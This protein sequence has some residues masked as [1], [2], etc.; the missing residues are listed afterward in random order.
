MLTTA[1]KGTPIASRVKGKPALVKSLRSLLIRVH[2]YGRCRA[3]RA[4]DLQWT[5]EL[6][7]ALYAALSKAERP[8][9]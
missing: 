7:D 1:E 9:D 8:R 5:A 4:E 3:R 6:L 2:R